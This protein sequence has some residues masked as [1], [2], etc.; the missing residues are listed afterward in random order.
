M[1]P[2]TPTSWPWI[3]PALRRRK[4]G[5]QLKDGYLTI[6]AAKGVDK[7][8]EDKKTR[9][10]IRQERSCGAPASVPSMWAM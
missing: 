6:S 9:R 8:E 2:K 1:K 5:I 3:C 10:V 7:D 4:S